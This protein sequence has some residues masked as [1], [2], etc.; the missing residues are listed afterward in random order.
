MVRGSS[1]H[2]RAT[3]SIGWAANSG[4]AFDHGKTEATIFRGK[5]T[6]PTAT[7]KVGTSTIPFN[8]EATRWLG[9]WLD[10][11]L[12]LKNHYAI[13][14]KGG[15]KAMARLRRLAGQM[16]LLPTNC[17]KAMTTCVQSV[18]MFGAELWCKGDYVRG[19]MGQAN[20]LQL[21]V[22]REARATTGSFRTTNLGA[23]WNRDS[24]QRQRSWRIGSGG[25]GY[26]YLPQGDRVREVVGAPT[27]IG[28]RLTNALA[29]RWKDGKHSFARGAGNPRRRAATRGGGRG[30]G[31]GREGSTG[32]HPCSPTGHGSTAVRQGTR[33]CA[34][35]ARPEWASNPH[36]LQ[37]RGL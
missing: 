35:G 16:G 22:N 1:T 6:A 31:G 5:K 2:S 26:D 32:T 8:K 23:Q 27:A 37:P 4:V 11:Q 14:L 17:R 10:S 36:G 12:T 24:G 34:R 30:K 7:I 33:W 13:R 3:S 29:L 18:A 21:L 9:V 25:L 19:T 15:K 28:Q 20:E